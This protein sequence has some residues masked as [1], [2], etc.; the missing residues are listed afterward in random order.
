MTDDI[1]YIRQAV[2]FIYEL[3]IGHG[4]VWDNGG[5]FPSI[6]NLGIEQRRFNLLPPAK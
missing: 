4:E 5:R 1:Y 2:K 3:S 6:I